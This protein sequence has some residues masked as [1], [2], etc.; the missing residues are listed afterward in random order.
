MLV[1]ISRS[2]IA[3][4]IREILYEIPQSID[5]RVEDWDYFGSHI[6]PPS[7]YEQDLEDLFWTFGG[8][9]ASYLA[10]FSYF[11]FLSSEQR[12]CQWKG[13]DREDLVASFPRFPNLRS[14]HVWFVDGIK[15]PFRW[16]TGRVLQD[17][18][19]GP[20]CAKDH[21]TKLATAMIA[22]KANGVKTHAFEMLG[23]YTRIDQGDSMLRSLVGKAFHH[24]RD[25]R[26][27]NSPTLLEFLTHVHMPSLR[28]FELGNCWLSIESLEEFVQCHRA[29][30]RVLHLEDV[31]MITE[32]IDSDGVYLSMASAETIFGK[33]A[34]IWN[35]GILSE[36]SINRQPGGQY[37]VRKVF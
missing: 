21:L 23:L 9:E 36:V 14:V 18:P 8:S 12:K 17:D 11:R 37:D 10:V 3:P 27:I 16:F 22:A 33:L 32:R 1:E 34:G 13:R 7:E 28:R 5:P 25:L 15:S 26:I 20:G 24:I 30:L 31:W 35:Y 6:Y 2:A 4:C 19:D 29:S